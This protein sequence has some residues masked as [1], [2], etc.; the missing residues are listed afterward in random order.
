MKTL[1]AIERP[2]AQRADAPYTIRLSHPN[3]EYEV[4]HTSPNKHRAPTAQEEVATM[5]LTVGFGTSGSP[6]RSTGPLSS[7]EI[8]LDPPSPGFQKI[9]K[10]LALFVQ[11]RL[12]ERALSLAYPPR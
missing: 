6:V 9:A 2:S 4:A 1:V 7:I 12:A 8:A 10:A 5:S 11:S 3:T